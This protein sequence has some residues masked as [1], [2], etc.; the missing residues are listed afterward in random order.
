[1]DG[2]SDLGKSVELAGGLNV[3]GKRERHFK[4]IPSLGR[5]KILMGTWQNLHSL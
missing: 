2:R 4:M 5:S 3:D 1:M